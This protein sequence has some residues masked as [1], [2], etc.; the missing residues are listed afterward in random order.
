MIELAIGPLI[1]RQATREQQGSI[2]ATW[3]EV[4]VR[5]CHF[6][7]GFTLLARSDVVPAG[8]IAVVYQ[9]LPSPLDASTEAFIDII[10]VVSA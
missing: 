6:E 4:A 5:H 7:D 2:H 1:I 8:L 9:P 3:G 10:E